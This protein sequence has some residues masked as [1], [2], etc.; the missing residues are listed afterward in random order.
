MV[1]NDVSFFV[2][3]FVFLCA[4]TMCSW[5]CFIGYTVFPQI[6]CAL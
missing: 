3:V 4:F 1:S 2:Y 5:C 6:S